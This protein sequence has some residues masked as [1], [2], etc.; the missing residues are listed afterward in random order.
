MYSVGLQPSLE[1]ISSNLTSWP[2]ICLAG[3]LAGWLYVSA[4]ERAQ[5]DAP[6]SLPGYR[7]SSIIPFFR[8][9]YDFLNWGFRFTEEPIFQ[10]SLLRNPV[11]V[12][13]GER[14]RKDFFNAKGL[15]LQEG[16]RVLSGA[17]PFVQGVTS[18]LR[19]R[20]IA[21]IYKRLAT[22]Q[23]ND[24]LTELIPEILE[25]SRRIMG[26]WGKSGT[27]DP[28]DRIY[29]LVFQT[30]VR[31]LTCAEIA[32][33]PVVVAR[34][35]ELYDRVDRGTTPA[36][37]LF[38][39]FP[40]PAM[41]MKFRATKEIYD[42]VVATIK[43]RKESGVSRNDSLQMLLDSGD[44][45]SM[46]V[47]FIMGLLIAG[48]R[49]TG[50]IASWMITLLGCHPEWRHKALLEVQALLSTHSI[51]NDPLN[52]TPTTQATLLSTIPL[53]VWESE[54]PVLDSLIRETLRMAQP[55]V[56]MRRNVGPDMY[57]GGKSVPSGAFA[58]YPFS[59]VHLNPDIYPDPWKFDPARAEGK[60]D[61][62]Y[63]GWGGGRVNCLGTRLAKVEMK[64]ITAM[65]LLEFDF[66]T[67]DA[68]GRIADPHPRPN[69]ND[70][71]SCRPSNGSYFLKY[72]HLASRAL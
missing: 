18:D 16:F 69:W 65:L 38:P 41:I 29:E 62:G 23:R 19:Q 11:V 61:F 71:L 8:Q 40:S 45:P 15:D 42:I 5:E 10:F 46:I 3:V 66:N 72:E 64:L 37:V 67:V 25:D 2:V 36:T 22:V 9:R 57:I 14:G 52:S 24:R 28:F 53:T 4:H 21:Q 54:M 63:I 35:K 48:A 7:L 49:S 33:D 6:V 27:F 50:T 56:A 26:S 59:D 44:E 58:I 55:H 39:W 43:V 34:L 31:C 13:S 20:R 68:G 47:G 60:G 32:N 17:L 1:L 51:N 12:V 70:T 30:T